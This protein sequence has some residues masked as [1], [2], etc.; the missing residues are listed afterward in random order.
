MT[1]QNTLSSP[2]V[3]ICIPACYRAR[4]DSNPELGKF[5]LNIL[6]RMQRNSHTKPVPD[7]FQNF[8]ID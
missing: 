8:L 4:A 2:K 6:K 1:G 7:A 3:E 5:S